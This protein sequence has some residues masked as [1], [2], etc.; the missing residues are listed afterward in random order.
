MI[1]TVTSS[2]EG[3]RQ[4]DLQMMLANNHCEAEITD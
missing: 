3:R 2:Q 4:R 1:D